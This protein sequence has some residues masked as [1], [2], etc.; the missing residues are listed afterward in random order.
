[1]Q[2]KVSNNYNKRVRTVLNK[3][4]Q[5]VESNDSVLHEKV[6]RNLSSKNVGLSW[7]ARTKNAREHGYSSLRGIDGESLSLFYPSPIKLNWQKV[8]I[9]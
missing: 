3:N 7:P 1:M 9:H 2:T 6:Q 5:V 4:Y 8:V